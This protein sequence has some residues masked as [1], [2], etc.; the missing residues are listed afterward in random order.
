MI[1][2]FITSFRK[3]RSHGRQP[4]GHCWS[5]ARDG[6]RAYAA[7]YSG[8]NVRSSCLSRSVSYSRSYPPYPP[9]PFGD[10]PR[11]NIGSSGP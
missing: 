8:W 1:P 5:V 10:P 11:L 4:G 7:S 9:I 6:H 3:S 2:P